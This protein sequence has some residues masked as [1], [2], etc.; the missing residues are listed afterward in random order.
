M[1]ITGKEQNSEILKEIG[2][3]IKE[4][5]LASDMS[6]SE[7]AE[8]C[9]LSISTIIRLEKGNDSKFSHY[10]NVLSVL[11]LLSNLDYLIPEPQENFEKIYNKRKQKQRV[12]KLK[13]QPKNQTRWIWGDEK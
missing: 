3:R 1:R 6:Q 11:G 4:Y 10:I 12:S 9:N 13:Q 8:E 7:L 2:N 5:R